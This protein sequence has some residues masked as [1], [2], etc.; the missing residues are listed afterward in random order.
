[1]GVYAHLWMAHFLQCFLSALTIGI[2]LVEEMGFGRWGLRDAAGTFIP[3]S[4]I[5]QILLWTVN[6]NNFISN[7][8]LSVAGENLANI[9]DDRDST[10]FNPSNTNNSCSDLS[11]TA[12]DYNPNNWSSSNGGVYTFK[13][14][15]SESVNIGAIRLRFHP[16]SNETH[17]GTRV[18][19][20]ST[21]TSGNKTNSQITS[22]TS[23]YL[24]NSFPDAS[25]GS[26]MLNFNPFANNITTLYVSVY[27][28]SQF[29][30]WLYDMSFRTS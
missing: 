21:S 2:L 11:G 17:R 27:K 6:Q 22:T 30:L 5:S 24:D 26:I 19:V 12:N 9:I 8:A 1:M 23:P 3:G 15:F 7:P 4:K 16:N 18:V 10:R 25:G 28:L 13:I 20:N 14:T 29:Q